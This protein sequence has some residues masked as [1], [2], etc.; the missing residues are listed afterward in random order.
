VI[1]LNSATEAGAPLSQTATIVNA[2]TGETLD[3]TT[4]LNTPTTGIDMSRYSATLGTVSGAITAPFYGL[5]TTR[6]VTGE[7]QTLDVA[8]SKSVSSSTDARFAAVNYVGV[9]DKTA[10][11]GPALGAVTV[12]GGSRPGATYTIQSGYDQTFEFDV[13]QGSGIG[14]RTVQVIMTRAYAD[15]SATQVVLQIPD[16]SKLSGFLSSWQITPGQSAS[17]TFYAVGA[18]LDVFKVNNQN[19]VAASRQTTF[20]P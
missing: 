16:L 15:A 4:S 19:Y 20:T 13:D 12:T 10:T 17:W 18:T 8:V 3:L 14:G 7:S 11:L 5:P 2:A 9:A 6:L 1:D